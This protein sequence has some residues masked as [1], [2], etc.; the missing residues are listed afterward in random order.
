[1]AKLGVSLL[2]QEKL[3]QGEAKLNVAIAMLDGEPL[4]RRYLGWL[5]EKR[6]NL[7]AASVHYLAAIKG[8]GLPVN[9]LTETHLALSRVYSATDRNQEVVRLM[10]PLVSKAGNGPLA[11]AAK[12]QLALAYIKLGRDEADPLIHSLEHSLKSDNPDFRYLMAN[13][14]FDTD[15][16][17]SRNILQALVKSDPVYS[18]RAG[19]MIARSY[20]VQ[21]KTS[22]ALKELER[23]ALGASKNELPGVLTAL[24]AVN[25]SAGKAADAGKVL[26]GYF[27]KYPDN[28]DIAYLLAETRL[29]MGDLVGAQ[30][31]LQQLA[32]KTPKNPQIFSLLGQIERSQKA[33]PLAE[34]HLKKATVLDSS[35]VNSWVNLAGV[36][37]SLNDR[38]R[39]EN[40]LKAG[41]GV[42]P[43]NAQLQYELAS[44]YESLGNQKEAVT[45]YRTILDANPTFV[46]ALSGMTIGLAESGELVRAKQYAEKAFKFGQS[47][48][49]FLD[50]YGWTLVLNREFEKGLPMLEKASR[51]MPGDAVTLYHLG[52]ALLLAGK[53]D[54]GKQAL[55]RSLVANPPE[56]VRAKVQA[57]LK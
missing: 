13:A 3:Q 11:P 49:I 45:L 38:A 20:A 46:P 39:A 51:G 23:L 12:M 8:N 27:K 44:F 43:G 25:V 42:N 7:K 1:V 2:L 50:A 28:P 24:I 17:G 48:P 6:G 37:M 36:Y 29:H 5:E 31:L 32:V 18:G 35:S 19:L 9:S 4:A 55:Q 57:L 54:A 41:L 33:F 47:D 30:T 26:D 56:N 53:V 34:Q 15:P 16:E 40:T 10:A 21:G 22:L 14:K 52:A